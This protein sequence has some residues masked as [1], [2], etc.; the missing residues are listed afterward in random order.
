MWAQ[1]LDA[2]CRFVPVE[3]ATLTPDRVAP[4]QVLLRVLAGGLCGSDL[5]PFRGHNTVMAADTGRTSPEI[6]GYP[7][8]EVVGE[9]VHSRH[10]DIAVGETV[11]GWAS[12]FDAIAEYCVTDGAGVWNYAGGRLARL[13]PE[14][15]VMV[16]PL[17]CVLYAAEQLDAQ[18]KSVA[19]IGLGPIGLLFA[20]VLAHRGARRVTGV[21]RVDRTDIGPAYGLTETIRASSDRWAGHLSDDDRPEVVVEA[22]GHIV[23]TLADGIRAAAFGGHVYYFGVPDDPVYPFPMKEFLRKNLSLSSGATVDRRRVLRE[24]GDYLASYPDILDGY[25]SHVYT[26]DDVQSAYTA[27]ATPCAGQTKIAVRMGD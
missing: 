19:V 26:A 7:M 11:V 8:H 14:R 23:S 10:A 27:A 2:P 12:G 4:G 6:P 20:H 25:V 9:V 21:D 22:V 18:D 17:A 5:P 15:A 13:K 16:Q 24:A 3:V 1:M